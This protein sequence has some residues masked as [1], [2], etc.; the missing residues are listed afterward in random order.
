MTITDRVNSFVKLGIILNK[1]AK[2]QPEHLFTSIE[3]SNPWFTS[4]NIKMALEGL[5]YMLSEASLLR[6]ASGYHQLQAISVK[7]RKVGLIMAGN[8]PA[9]GFHDMMCILLSGHTLIAKKSSKD[10]ILPAFIAG[11]LIETD[12]RWQDKIIFSD[13]M[14]GVDA[15]IT[16]GSDNSARYFHY[17][18]STIPHIIRKNRSSV[19]IIQGDETD[20]DLQKL[21]GD[22]FSYFGLGCRNISKLYIPHEQILHRFMDANASYISL[23]DHHKYANN[24][25][26]NKALYTMNL[27][28]HLDS[29]YAIFAQNE[30]LSSPVSVIF[31]QFYASMAEVEHILYKQSDKIQCISAK[32]SHNLPTIPFGQCQIPAISDFADGIDTMEFLIGLS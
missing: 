6:F 7:P 11:Q 31:Y 8:I 9:V 15:V 18:F 21:A 29:G 25:L 24:Y 30:Q 2:E 16:T 17:Y 19:A 32:K 23:M 10:D 3:R 1:V 4:G 22:V 12:S 28:P 5:S 20:A 27:Q 13:Q 14:R 26:Y